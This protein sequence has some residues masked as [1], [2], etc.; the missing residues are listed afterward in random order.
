MRRPIQKRIFDGQISRQY[1]KN[2]TIRR[3]DVGQAEEAMGSVDPRIRTVP[4]FVRELQDANKNYFFLDFFAF[5][6]WKVNLHHF[7]L[8]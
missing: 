6:F 4:L 5:Y 8:W 2:K 1:E 7:F 3:E